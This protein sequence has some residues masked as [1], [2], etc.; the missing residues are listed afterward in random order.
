MKG[1]ELAYKTVKAPNATCTTLLC[2]VFAE[3]ITDVV[4]Q[5]CLYDL[6]A[7]AVV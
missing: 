4:T 7:V 2:K 1:N 3:D 6:Q 5:N